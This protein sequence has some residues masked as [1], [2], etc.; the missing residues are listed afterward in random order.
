M[1][2]DGC[3]LVAALIDAT[4]ESTILEHNMYVRHPDSL[5]HGH[6]GEGRV[7]LVGDAAHPVRPASGASAL[8]CVLLPPTAS[9][10]YSTQHGAVLLCD[11]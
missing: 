3:K 11:L 5:S 4:D 2:G 10:K 1:W 6:W 8:R 7:T 9:C